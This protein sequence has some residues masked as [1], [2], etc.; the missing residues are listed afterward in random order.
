[1]ASWSTCPDLSAADVGD[2]C[3]GA[4]VMAF[5]SSGREQAGSEFHIHDRKS[6]VVKIFS[7]T[8]TVA[9]FEVDPGVVERTCLP[10]TEQFGRAVDVDVA[11]D[12]R[13]DQT[14]A[15]ALVPVIQVSD[16]VSGTGSEA[17]VEVDVSFSGSGPTR[18]ID[19]R[20]HVTDRYVMWLEGTKG[21]ERDCQATATFDGV[22][23]PGE[24]VACSMSRVRQAEVRVYHGL[25]S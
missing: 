14:H 4:D 12:P 5:Y 8:C 25:P 9:D 21:W 7:Y 19:E 1:M 18:R 24:L 13:L 15:T 10:A 11:V 17:T 3:S 16:W 6:G 22:T 2:M 20:T 23:V